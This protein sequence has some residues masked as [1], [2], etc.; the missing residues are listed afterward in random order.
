MNSRLGIIGLAMMVSVGMWGCQTSGSART[1]ER[2]AA[3]NSD[4]Q[5]TMARQQTT[6]QQA[7]EQQAAQQP[8]GQSSSQIPDTGRMQSLP[9]TT[10]S[11]AAT[12]QGQN[13]PAIGTQTVRGEVLKID[14]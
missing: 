13:L 12:S 3:D 5:Q 10:E 8:S 6:Q 2:T 4:S 9:Q 7:S 14:G 1:D 11:T